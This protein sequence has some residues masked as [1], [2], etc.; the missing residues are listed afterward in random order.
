MTTIPDL[1]PNAVTKLLSYLQLSDLLTATS[2]C[3][4]WHSASASDSIWQNI[5]DS[6]LHLDTSTFHTAKHAVTHACT[7]ALSCCG[8][9]PSI[10]SPN[11]RSTT[12]HTT[13]FK[14]WDAKYTCPAAQDLPL[15]PDAA[16]LRVA[17]GQKHVVLLTANGEVFDSRASAEGDARQV[18]GPSSSVLL[19]P[20]LWQPPG[21]K[22]RAIAAGESLACLL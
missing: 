1:P 17:A 7:A 22:I 12:R 11:S 16:L 13:P 3:K 15:Q 6:Q 14:V 5:S 4:A 9:V 20:K 10:S 8:M 18:T 2:V 19:M 21:L